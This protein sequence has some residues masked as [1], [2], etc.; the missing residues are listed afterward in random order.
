MKTP[1]EL[2]DDAKHA[3]A[4]MENHCEAV[5]E[6]AGLLSVLMAGPDAETAMEGMHRLMLEIRGRADD[7]RTFHD[8]ATRAVHRLANP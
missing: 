6:Y 2:I 3:L 4:A 1:T 5:Y 8:D 7:L